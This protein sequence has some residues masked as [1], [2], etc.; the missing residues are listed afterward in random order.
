[1]VALSGLQC[2]I[3][4]GTL[5]GAWS[6]KL[7]LSLHGIR[8][9]KVCQ[10]LCS[11]FVHMMDRDLGQSCAFPSGWNVKIRLEDRRYVDS[12][13][14]F[15]SS[16]ISSAGFDIGMGS[17]I[18]DFLPRGCT[19]GRMS[20]PLIGGIE[21]HRAMLIRHNSFS[22]GGLLLSRL[23]CHCCT[24]TYERSIGQTE[25]VSYL[26]FLGTLR[27]RESRQNDHGALC[28]LYIAL[29]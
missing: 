19:Q 20:P 8:Y 27:Y 18:A 3:K 22:L 6:K 25:A 11:P 10:N 9:E 1:M 21:P 28:L 16:K 7:S 5:E 29:S 12:P 4:P 26:F 24:A 13:P 14:W 23:G 2:Q 17:I 15:K